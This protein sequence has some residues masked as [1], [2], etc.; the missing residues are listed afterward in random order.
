MKKIFFSSLVATLIFIPSTASAALVPACATTGNGGI[1]CAMLMLSNITKL[2]LG[3]VGAGSLLFFMYGGFSWITSMGS[4]EKVQK[5]KTIM[6]NTIIG[7][8]IVLIAWTVVNFTIYTLTDTAEG[9]NVL[10]GPNQKWYQICEDVDLCEEQGAGWSCQDISG[11][12]LSEATREA[13]ET[14][15]NCALNLCSGGNNTVCCNPNLP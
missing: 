8:F 5:G 13:C 1:C 3:I 12:G 14:A 10:T 6:L 15:D 2:I 9:N 7:I 4:P 11:C